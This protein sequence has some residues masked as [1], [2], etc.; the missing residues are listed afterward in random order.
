MNILYLAFS[1][2]FIALT[3]S[4]LIAVALAFLIAAMPHSR[5]DLPL[6]VA[7]AAFAALS[8]L[9]M[10]DLFQTKHAVLRN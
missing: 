2:R 10:R 5:L 4:L 7:L 1:H 8:A 3:L 9:G 6:G